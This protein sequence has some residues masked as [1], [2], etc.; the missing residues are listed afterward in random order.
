[1]TE[2]DVPLDVATATA[3]VVTLATHLQ[4]GDV[5][6][7]EDFD[8]DLEALEVF[9]YNFQDPAFLVDADVVEAFLPMISSPELPS[10]LP[11][12]AFDCLR[13]AITKD[14][15]TVMT[16]LLQS[17]ADVDAGLLDA[18]IRYA[19]RQKI[20]WRFIL[21][22]IHRHPDA[23][24]HAFYADVLHAIEIEA[25]TIHTDRAST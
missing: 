14:P 23:R 20:E 17:E 10:P 15:T 24:N 16:V 18:L 25:Q 3:R 21:D 19:V 22:L 7:I 8:A 2:H 1:M 11:A 4:R 9:L 12:D 5:N 13:L 6:R